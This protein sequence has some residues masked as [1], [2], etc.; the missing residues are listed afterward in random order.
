[1]IPCSFEWNGDWSDASALWTPAFKAEVCHS[2]R[3]LRGAWCSPATSSVKVPRTSVVS[4]T[5]AGVQHRFCVCLRFV[6]VK[7]VDDKD[8]GAFWMVRR[9]PVVLFFLVWPAP[10]MTHDAAVIMTESL[11]VHVMCAPPLTAVLRRLPQVLCARG[12]VPTGH[13][14]WGRV[15]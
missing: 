11:S 12:G 15:E 4:G 5:S 10:A 6:Q 1:M 8:D 3:M 14:P 9:A 2:A 7:F 13:L